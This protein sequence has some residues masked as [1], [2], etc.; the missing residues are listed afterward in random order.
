MPGAGKT[1]VGVLLAERLGFSFLD[2][3][4]AIQAR[5]GRRLQE[6][7]DSDGR[8]AFG[9]IEERAILALAVDGHVIAT[10]GSAV[11]SARAMQHLAAIGAICHL[12]ADPTCLRGRIDNL[13]S[14]GIAMAPGQ[15]LTALYAERR[16][17]YLQYAEVSIDCTD[18]DPAEVVRHLL[19]RLEKRFPQRT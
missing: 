8:T 4:I 6:I 1:T 18:L 3:D 12:D 11:Y 9:H 15:D 13:E 2:T 16:P 14:R 17:L 10:G 5:E 7:I 19:R